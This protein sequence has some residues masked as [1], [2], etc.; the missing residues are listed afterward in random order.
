MAKNRLQ[1]K[2][3]APLQ[4]GLRRAEETARIGRDEPIQSLRPV[5]DDSMSSM[6]PGD[7][8]LLPNDG[9]SGVNLD[10]VFHAVL[11]CPRCGTLTPISP[12]QYSGGVPVICCSDS[13]SCRFRIDQESRLV[14]LPVM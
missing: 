1:S 6:Q 9:L 2:S 7:I 8:L 14:Y 12:A 11:A 4:E 3:V 5:D 13:C 10:A